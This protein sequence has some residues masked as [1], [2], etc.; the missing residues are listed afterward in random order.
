[1]KKYWDIAKEQVTN[2]IIS[3]WRS[4]SIFDKGKLIFIGVAL[5]FVL[6][7]LLYSLFV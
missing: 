2:Y 3:N 5:F 7:K 4:D 6:W 1:M